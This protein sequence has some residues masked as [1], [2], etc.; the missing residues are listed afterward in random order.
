MDE[1]RSVVE[2]IERA[3]RCTSGEIRVHIEPKCARNPMLRAMKVFGLLGMENTAERNGV[4]IYVAFESR[5]FAIIGDKGINERVGVGFWE[6][7]K[8][9]ILRAF[10]E[11]RFGEGLCSAI[12]LIGRSLGEFF[13]HK[14]D[15][16][17]ELS[18]EISYSE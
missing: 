10:S 4:L 13:P 7:A 17:N 3:E 15:D 1:Q 6:D 18:D 11:S 12:E 9:R 5:K 8:A 16:K 2:S 14:T